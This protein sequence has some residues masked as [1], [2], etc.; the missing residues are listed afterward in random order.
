MNL[1][2]LI[3]LGKCIRKE[4]EIT[5]HFTRNYSHLNRMIKLLLIRIRFDGDKNSGNIIERVDLTNNLV[6]TKVKQVI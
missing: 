5:S 3:N 1:Y 4:G 6:I 2:A